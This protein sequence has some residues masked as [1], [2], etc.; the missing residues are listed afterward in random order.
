MVKKGSIGAA[1][2]GPDELGYR[3]SV[4]VLVDINPTCRGMLE[5][6]CRR[7]NPKKGDKLVLA[8]AGGLDSHGIETSAAKR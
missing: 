1:L 5:W 7:L 4:K 3:P 8:K 2:A 6:L